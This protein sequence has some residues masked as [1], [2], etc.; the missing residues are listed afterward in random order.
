MYGL[1]Y[2]LSDIRLSIIFTEIYTGGLHIYEGSSRASIK[3]KV[4]YLYI[5][6]SDLVYSYIDTNIK[7]Q[8]CLE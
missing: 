2:Y 1:Y 3:I 6:L 7:L 8:E 5:R 4:I